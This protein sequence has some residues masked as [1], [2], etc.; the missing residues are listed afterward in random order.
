MQQAVKLPLGIKVIIG[1]YLLCI[2]S[3]TIGQGGALVLYDTV[4]KWGLQE[5]RES[6]APAIVEVNKGF[7]FADI[8]VQIPLLVLTTVGLRQRR[9][10]GVVGSWLVL[11]INIYWPIVIWATQYFFKQA[12][13]KYHPLDTSINGFIVFVFLFAM[14]ASW[15]LFRNRRLFD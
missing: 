7:A 4:A 2:V 12:G 6:L 3:W 1:F 9:F 15:Y 13:V 8:V 11:G 14:W 5:P 10:Y